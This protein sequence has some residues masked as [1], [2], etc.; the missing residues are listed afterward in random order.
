ML[1][2]HLARA[3]CGQVEQSPRSRRSDAPQG[4]GR[5]AAGDLGRAARGRARRRRGSAASAPG[6]LG[7]VLAPASSV[8]AS[9]R[10]LLRHRDR[11]A[12]ARRGGRSPTRRLWSLRACSGRSARGDRAV[13]RQDQV[14]QAAQRIRAAAAADRAAGRGRV[15]EL[16]G[17]AGRQLAEGGQSSRC[18]R[19]SRRRRRWLRPAMAVSTTRA[20]VGSS[21][22]S[23]RKRS[24]RDADHPAAAP[25]RVPVARAGPPVEHRQLAGEAARAV[26]GEERLLAAARAWWPGPRPRGR[27]RSR[28]RRIPR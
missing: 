14:L 25:T 11:A 27:R 26:D 24:G 18:W 16:V 13:A 10:S 28:G 17:E 15:V 4:L 19:S 5:R 2:S 21:A 6:V 1:C 22:I 9:S 3:G 8:S 7:A 20:T 12:A 23:R